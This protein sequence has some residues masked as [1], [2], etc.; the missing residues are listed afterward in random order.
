MKFSDYIN[1]E[2]LTEA[3]MVSFDK[4]TSTTSKVNVPYLDV[5]M[6][7]EDNREAYPLR[8]HPDLMKYNIKVVKQLIDV[9][10]NANIKL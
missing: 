3:E 1:E 6:K 5:V 8:I 9:I 7:T 10:K 4:V 2:T